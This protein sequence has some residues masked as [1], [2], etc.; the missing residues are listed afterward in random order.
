MIVIIVILN[1]YY[2]IVS[3]IGYRKK[4]VL[5]SFGIHLFWKELVAHQVLLLKLHYR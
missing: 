4:A 1:M 3:Q 2:M 5:E